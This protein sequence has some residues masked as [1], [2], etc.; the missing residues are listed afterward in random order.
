MLLRPNI[1]RRLGLLALSSL[2]VAAAAAAVHPIR[3]VASSSPVRSQFQ[4]KAQSAASV[5]PIA[6]T[7]PIGVDPARAPDPNSLFVV[8]VIPPQAVFIGVVRSQR[9][10]FVRYGKVEDPSNPYL[11]VGISREFDPAWLRDAPATSKR[12]LGG[13]DVV[14]M[15]STSDG[16]KL[17]WAAWWTE[18]NGDV[19]GLVVY[20]LDI[21][22]LERILPNIVRA[23]PGLATT[24]TNA[25]DPSYLYR[26]GPSSV[27]QTFATGGR[28][29]TAWK[30]QVF[31]PPGYP[32][33]VWERR[34]LC[35]QIVLAT[36][37]AG[38]LVC[39]PRTTTTSVRD[40]ATRHLAVVGP[41]SQA[42]TAA[43]V[44][45]HTFSF[46]GIASQGIVHKPGP[47]V[48]GRRIVTGPIKA[49]VVVAT[50]PATVCWVSLSPSTS[51]PDV[52]TAF[53]EDDPA[54]P[55]TKAIGLLTP[56]Q[57]GRVAPVSEVPR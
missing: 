32:I 56:N 7:R 55:C 47:V 8:S 11:E 15:E 31:V 2:V 13:R 34:H 22:A 33:A 37:K 6:D 9:G 52:G 48:R 18:A 50:V 29:K 26:R 28:G 42:S 30:L 14:I 20:D 49:A 24:L 23:G 1:A 57:K 27:A 41:A 12:R 44:R 46:T 35:W 36:G 17:G 51:Q 25:S 21:A 45:V 16:S 54:D 3:L 5:P 53:A 10:G 39:D 4:V 40:R 19:V 43:N 38:N